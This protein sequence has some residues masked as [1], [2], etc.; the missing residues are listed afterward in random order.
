[1]RV[2]TIGYTIKSPVAIKNENS[3][4]TTNVIKTSK[5]SSLSALENYNKAMISFKG[6]GGSS[7]EK[8]KEK[9]RRFL[10]HTCTLNYPQR[11][12]DDIMRFINEDNIEFITKAV[13]E[14]YSVNRSLLRDVPTMVLCANEDNVE[15]GMMMLNNPDFPR[16]QIYP[17]ILNSDR[18]NAEFG[19]M[20]LDEPN[21]PSEEISPILYW[22]DEDNIELGKMML[23][24]PDFPREEM[25]AILE[26]TYDDKLEP[27][28]AMVSDPNFPRDQISYTLFRLNKDNIE[29][30]NAMI[31]NP[32][33]PREDIA[34]IL[35]ASG[36]SNIEAAKII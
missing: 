33:F 36:E 8:D 5:E 9:L 15:L 24:D 23:D 27:A 28:K 7:Y 1:M 17:V 11:E 14:F 19:K 6:D 16:E 13:H 32:D 12:S 2:N 3:P 21:F 35:K 34:D 4:L 10:E 29:L 20:M 30:F 26:E 22:I 31:S 25:A 18:Y